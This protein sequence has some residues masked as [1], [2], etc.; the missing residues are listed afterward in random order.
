MPAWFSAHCL[1]ADWACWSTIAGRQPAGHPLWADSP[2]L[3]GTMEPR[4]A[5]SLSLSTDGGPGCEA[6]LLPPPP[7]PPP[8]PLTGRTFGR[9]AVLP[10]APPPP[11]P[12]ALTGR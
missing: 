7:P 3:L 9:D 2:V 4:T 12:R 6:A 10:I 11:L 5:M 1:W 8:R